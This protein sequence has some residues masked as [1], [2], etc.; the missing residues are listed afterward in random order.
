MS[1]IRCIPINNL[2]TYNLTLVVGGN[3]DSDS[4][5][6][7]TLSPANAQVSDLGLVAQIPNNIGQS[8]QNGYYLSMVSHAWEKERCEGAG[9]LTSNHLIRNPMSTLEVQ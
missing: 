9:L 1:A 4:R 2:T 7:I 3:L 5:P 8:I 6:L